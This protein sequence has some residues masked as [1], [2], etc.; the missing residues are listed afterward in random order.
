MLNSAIRSSGLDVVGEH[1]QCRKRQ[2][3]DHLSPEEKLLR[4]KMKNRA[5]A[6]SARDRKKAHMDELEIE[7]DI[8]RQEKRRLAV[9]NERLR[10][11]LAEQQKQIEILQQRLNETGVDVATKAGQKVQEITV[12][13][14]DSFKHASLISG[15]Q[16]KDQA[17]LIL[18]LLFLF[19]LT[20]PAASWMKVPRMTNH[21]TCPSSTTKTLSPS[22]SVSHLRTL[23]R[24]NRLNLLSSRWSPHRLKT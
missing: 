23:K 17:L 7:V 5:A 6:Q 8:L 18:F 4:R 10:D 12:I 9:E 20:R 14:D 19:S 21:N 11:A 3:L 15:P 22:C 16:Q 2:R 13:D 24:S 1:K